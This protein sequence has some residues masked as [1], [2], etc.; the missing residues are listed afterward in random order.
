MA[1]L[2]WF[3]L[4]GNIPLS[5][6]QFDTPKMILPNIDGIEYEAVRFTGIDLGNDSFSWNGKIQGTRS[7]FVSLAVVKGDSTI[8]VSFTDGVTY[9]Y[10]GKSTKIVE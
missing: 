7:G 1:W 3:P 2:I 5:N 10:K 4:L 8:T 9:S 6:V